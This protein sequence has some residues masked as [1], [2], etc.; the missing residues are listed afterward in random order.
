MKKK[1][2]SIVGM[3]VCLLG[4]MSCATQTYVT[5]DSKVPAA[6]VRP[7][8]VASIALINETQY[9]LSNVGADINHVLAEQLV[10]DKD[11]LVVTV[12]DSLIENDMQAD[13]IKTLAK[14]LKVDCLI[15]L[16]SL[17]LTFTGRNKGDKVP[18]ITWQD[19]LTSL[20]DI[21]SGVQSYAQLFAV[22]NVYV[23]GKPIPYAQILINDHLDWAAYAETEHEAV[24]Y[25]PSTEEKIPEIIDCV[26]FNL[27]RKLLPYWETVNRPL[28]VHGNSTLE[29]AKH[30]VDDNQ[31]DQAAVLW[32]EIY[33]NEDAYRIKALA[34]HNLFVYYEKIS[35]PDK[36][37]EWC[38]KGAVYFER[39][40]SSSATGFL[41][42]QIPELEKK[43]EELKRLDQQAAAE[44]N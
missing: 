33:K 34:A 43:K 26:A 28:Y 22:M 16:D 40:G 29:R 18:L 13:D 12:L 9:S 31:W 19:V 36:A 35:N 8:T 27:K 42:K 1:L 3:I 38:R 21:D 10:E 25:L 5:Y 7:A 23:P 11:F 15:S 37:I 17:Q 14:S 24:D 39:A 4:V 44:L 41:L 6:W 30:Y 32:R 2:L 20:L